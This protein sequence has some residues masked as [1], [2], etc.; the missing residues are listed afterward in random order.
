VK[1]TRN[2]NRI[3]HSRHPRQRRNGPVCCMMH[4]TR[5]LQTTSRSSRRDYSVAAGVISAACMLFIRSFPPS[6]PNNIRGGNVRLSADVCPSVRPQK[7]CPISMKFVMYIE[8]DEWCMTLCR[9]TRFKVKVKVTGPL[10]FRKLYFSKSIS[11]AIYRGS[12][13]MTTNS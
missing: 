9:M 7:V 13:Q 8:V 11:C 1:V 3:V 6:R 10:K 12:W 5:S 2:K 4:C